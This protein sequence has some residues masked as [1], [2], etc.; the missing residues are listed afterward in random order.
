MDGTTMRISSSRSSDQGRREGDPARPATGLRHRDAERRRYPCRE[1]PGRGT[2]SRSNLPRVEA[3][4]RRTSRHGATATSPQRDHHARGRRAGDVRALM[5]DVARRLRLPCA[6]RGSSEDALRSGRHEDPI[7]LLITDVVMSG[8]NGIE[9]A[10]RSRCCW[11]DEGVYMTGTATRRSLRLGRS[12]APHPPEAVHDERLARAC[13]MLGGFAP[14][15]LRKEPGPAGVWRL[16]LCRE[17]A[18]PPPNR[19]VRVTTPPARAL[20]QP[21]S[22]PAGPRPRLVLVRRGAAPLEARDLRQARVLHGC[23]PVAH[24]L[25][26]IHPLERRHRHSIFTSIRM[27]VV[28][29]ARPEVPCGPASAPCRCCRRLHGRTMR[30]GG[31]ASDS[32]PW[33]ST[34]AL[35]R[36]RAGPEHDMPCW[37][38]AGRELGRR[39]S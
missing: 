1:D 27:Q 36:W 20:S 30:D 4:A 18:S 19:H 8:M 35:P 5:R 9:L 28:A 3:P 33:S 39:E 22:A 14:S 7:D 6:L 21:A 13:A 31:R 10:A 11:R 29:M 23:D 17:A 24:P 16:L 37:R 26:V 32:E 34:M 38:R 2:S 12:E 25:R 15:R